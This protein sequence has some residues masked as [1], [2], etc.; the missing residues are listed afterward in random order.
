M[1]SS[2]E[3]QSYTLARFVGDLRAIAAASSDD[4][5]VAQQVRPLAQR[6]ALEGRLL[7]RRKLEFD[8]QQG[9]SFHILHEEADHTLSVAL[10]S[11][12]PGRGTP[13]HNHGSWGVVV[14]VDGDEKNTF[15][16]RVDDGAKA[17]Y[18]KLNKINEKTFAV[19][20]VIVLLRDTIHSVINETDRV[21]TSLHVYG[22]NVNYTGRSQFD[23][24]AEREIPWLVKQT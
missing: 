8:P 4:K 13:P 2:P 22:K 6:L 20:E 15:W 11:W 10:L 24:A 3:S 23:V 1:P 7:E 17:G 5:V 12:L 9:F 16:R 14:G 21:S 19:G 18:A